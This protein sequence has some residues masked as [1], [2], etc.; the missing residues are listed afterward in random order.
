MGQTFF[1]VI[2]A[3]TIIT[4]I[5]YYAQIGKWYST[6]KK[7]PD[8]S[9]S[10]CDPTAKPTITVLIPFRDES[11]NLVALLHSLAIQKASHWDVILIDDHSTDDSLAVIKAHRNLFSVNVSVVP[12]NGEGKKAALL[13]GA[14]TATGDYLLMT[15]AD[16]S[17]PDSWI[18]T[19]QQWI[20]KEGSELIIGP[21][22]LTG[23]PTFFNR[24]QKRDFLALQ[25]SG[26]SATLGQRPIMSNG[27]NLA[28]QRDLFLTANL[29]TEFA[30]GDDMF[31]LEWMKQQKRTISFLKTPSALVLT[32]TEKNWSDFLNQRARWA[33]KAKGYKDKD[34]LTIGV[35]IATT[36][37]LLTLC[38]IMSTIYP[39]LA[40]VWISLFLMK[41]LADFQLLR[42]GSAFYSYRDR[43]FE[44]F[45][46]QFFYP[47]YI[48][49]TLAYP[50][51]RTVRW[52]KRAI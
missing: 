30:S 45:L 4:C 49:T 43:L 48:L 40:I 52:K 39:L 21:V 27:A 44:F 13:T 7:T 19:Y 50:R 42:L 33:S 11:S 26:A 18:S 17:V 37:A 2:A 51:F 35:L 12:N 29:K 23:L 6:W 25:I 5:I 32:A 8:F 14:Q 22:F 28:C 24:Y 34:I 31:L 46:S 1:I 41:T 3:I 47:F 10:S 16:C 20:K 9:P 36:N 38:L 15:D